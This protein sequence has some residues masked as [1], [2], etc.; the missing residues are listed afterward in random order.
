MRSTKTSMNKKKKWAKRRAGARAQEKQLTR[1]PTEKGGVRESNFWKS[2]IWRI[3]ILLILVGVTILLGRFGILHT[4]ETVVL[5]TQMRLNPPPVRSDVVVVDITD[6]DFKTIFDEKRPLSPAALHDLIDAIAW[7]NPR[8]IGV[9]IDT[10]AQQY[11]EFKTEQCWPHIVW[12]QEVEEL[13]HGFEDSL[14]PLK[15]LGGRDLTAKELA[16]PPLLIESGEDKVTRRYRRCLPV[17]QSELRP[18]LPWAVYS[19]FKD[20]ASHDPCGHLHEP[21]DELFIRFAGDE[22]GSHRIRLSA[23]RLLELSKKWVRDEQSECPRGKGSPLD[24]KIILLGGTYLGEDRHDTP[25]GRMTGLDILS[26]TIETELMGGGFPEP[27]KISLYLVEIFGGVVLF[28]LF[29][30]YGSHPH[31]FLRALSIALLISPVIVLASSLLAFHSFSRWAF[32]APMVI[33][34]IL[35]ESFVEFRN[36]WLADTLKEFEKTSHPE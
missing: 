31:G 19:L 26:N 12:E 32:F 5:D 11:K 16:S 3:P 14:K 28:V 25:L 15:V 29:H 10:S 6:E 1:S 21:E 18:S 2:L 24:G 36:H 20:G 13:P 22:A 33:G 34:V 35:Y 27:S 23:S 4:L 7:G 17:S 9:D 30:H 8:V